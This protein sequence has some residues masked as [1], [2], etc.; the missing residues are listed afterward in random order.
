MDIALFGS[1]RT[2]LPVGWTKETSLS[3]FGGSH[4]DATA[5]SGEGAALTVIGIFG[6][7]HVELAPGAQVDD[8]GFSLFGGRTIAVHPG[9]GPVVRLRSYTLLGGIRVESA[10]AGS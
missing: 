2:K 4:I 10:K 3:M 5:P 1:R 9:D 6:G 8:G 7:V